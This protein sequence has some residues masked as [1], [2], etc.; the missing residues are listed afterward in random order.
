MCTRAM[1]CQSATFGEL[2][3]PLCLPHLLVLGTVPCGVPES[4]LAPPA[5]PELL[6]VLLP[7]PPVSLR[8]QRH[9]ATMAFFL[10]SR[11]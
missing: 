9:A 8:L 5:G 10:D 7:L 6:T 4:L 11:D 1:G 2:L 3:L